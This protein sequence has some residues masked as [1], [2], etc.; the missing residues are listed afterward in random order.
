VRQHVVL[1]ADLAPK[2]EP[3]DVAAASC[4]TQDGV[5]ST[6]GTRAH[7]RPWS[8]TAVSTTLPKHEDAALV[9]GAHR[10]YALLADE[11]GTSLVVLG[12]GSGG[13]GGAG[14]AST[15]TSLLKES[16]FGEDEQR[17]RA[18]YTVGDDLGVVRLATSGALAIREMR[19]GTVGPLRRLT[20]KIPHDDD[21][22]AVDASASTI[23]VVY[24]QDVGDACA[25]TGGSG[26]STKV[27][28]LRVDRTTG[29]ES[30]VE[31][32]PGMC[33]REVGPFFTGVVDASVSVA[34]VERVPVVS[35]A[36]APIAGLAHRLVGGGPAAAPAP[37]A[38]RIEQAADALVDAGCDATRCYAVALV[39]RSEADMM[40][41]G[42]A[43]VLRY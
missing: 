20:Q 4:A 1:G 8:G 15:R 42:F 10:A 24:T 25:K 31:L 37:A 2:A 16:D 11:G 13:D 40:T 3:A 17:E 21:V 35:K 43:R 9:C 29:G 18:E 39:R 26:P 5:W 34:W 41:P 38:L 22:V 32:S 33:G 19:G 6:D 7:G 36:R 23:V 30:V 12:G 28:A 27:M 14:D